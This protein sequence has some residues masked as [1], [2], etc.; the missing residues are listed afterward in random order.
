MSGTA[1]FTIVEDMIE[2]IMPTITVSSTSQ[3]N[4]GP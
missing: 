2:A 1:T 4:R 3:R